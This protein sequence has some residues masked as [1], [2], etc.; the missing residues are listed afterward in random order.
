MSG[1]TVFLDLN[2]NLEQDDGEPTGLSD[3]QGR[4]E[5]AASAG[6]VGPNATWVAR[7][8]PVAH[9]SADGGLDLRAADRVAAPLVAWS[10]GQP[11]QVLIT[12]LSTLAFAAQRWE[13][14]SPEQAALRAQHLAGMPQ[15]APADY[16]EG[17]SEQPI[18]QAR[19][20]ADAWGQAV[21]TVRN[22]VADDLDLLQDQVLAQAY[23]M[24]VEQADAWRAGESIN[25]D[26]GSTKS[27][28]YGAGP[29][30]GPGPGPTTRSFVVMFKDSV[31]NPTTQAQ[32]LM[33]GRGGQIRQVYTRVAKGFAATLPAAA[34]DAFAQAMAQHPAV[35]S[36]DDDIRMS[37]QQTVQTGATWG[38]DRTDQRLLPLSGSYSYTSTGIGVNAYVVDTGILSAHTTFGSR[39]RGGYSAIVDGRGTQ[40]CNGHGTHVAGTIGSSTWGMAKGVAL[41]P[42]RVLDCTG[43][44]SMSGVLAGL[45]W[46]AINAVRPAVVN[47]SLGGAASSTIDNAVAQLA[48][49][50]IA[51]VAAAG[52]SGADACTA[53][54]ARAP[55][56]ITVAATTNTDARASYS[57]WGTCVDVFAPGTSIT[58]A[59]STSPTAS[60]TISGTSMAAPHV[61][62]WAALW[63]QRNPT[64]TPAQL[65]DAIKATATTARVTDPRAGTPNLLLFSGSTSSTPSPAPSPTPT[66][67]PTPSPSLRL[68]SVS[69]FMAVSAR[70]ATGWKA[71]VTVTV[72]DSRG[73]LVPGA[74]VTGAFSAGGSSVS[75]TTATNGQCAVQTTNLSSQTAQISYT[76]R[77]ITGTGLSY[78]PARA[79]ISTIT[80]RRP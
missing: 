32:E 28:V 40:D 54:P 48:A 38:L 58:S 19:R 13:Q 10:D 53:S 37:T 12:P 31:A 61:T 7:V 17:T 25:A 60:N 21:Q 16:A 71:G 64:G 43:S 14:L 80:I 22:A 3:E 30:I 49:R 44:G 50:G 77:G 9:D 55:A 65:A 4:F 70:T 74:V 1:A 5:V 27:A 6:Q 35:E 67:A 66:P 41:Y 24:L 73:V 42:V 59:W 63:L 33:R 2:G 23:A 8:S 72:R 51:V 47:M 68:V 79:L 39:V 56:A 78:D 18:L 46:I 15:W 62:G 52:N 57:N 26:A 36:L 69:G 29:S 75:C 45:D 11:S 34:A 20:T 76:V